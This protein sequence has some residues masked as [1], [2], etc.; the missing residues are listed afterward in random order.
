MVA[1]WLAATAVAGRSWWQV[2]AAPYH[3][4]LAMWHLAAAGSVLLAAATIAPV[5]IP[6]GLLV[7][8]LAWSRRIYAM[9]TGTGGLPPAP[10]PPSTGGSGGTRSAP[11]GPGSPRPA[12]CRCSPA[13]GPSWPAP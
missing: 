4:W 5:A 3:A 6:L 8:A 9:E 2:A 1:V 12:R 7:G 11:P 13:T 10:R